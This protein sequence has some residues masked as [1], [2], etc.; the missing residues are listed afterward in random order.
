[1]YR[2]VLCIACLLS[3]PAA[4]R[5]QWPARPIPD[6]PRS[7]NGTVILTA[8]APRTSGG[9]PDLSGLWIPE[10]DPRGRPAGVEN[11]VFPRYLM[12]VAQDLTETNVLVPAAEALYRERLATDGVNDPIA[13]CQP[14][15]SPRVFSLPK[16]TKIVETPGLML[17]LHEHDTTYRQIF[18]DGRP[19]PEDPVPTGWATPSADGTT[20]RS[21]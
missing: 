20:T 12:N 2:I 11:V 16:P 3:V 1:M 4:A 7:G 18:A 9:T 6:L 15:G 8:P 21:W 17:L 14:P 10:P 13:H 5:P 19:L